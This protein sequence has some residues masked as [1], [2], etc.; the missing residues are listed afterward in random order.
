MC[1]KLSRSFFYYIF[2]YRQALERKQLILGRLVDI[3]TDLFAM[4][5]TLAYAISLHE[6]ENRT[7]SFELADT[8][9]KITSH[10][11]ND[12]YHS[13]HYNEDRSCNALA[14]KILNQEALWL[15]EGIL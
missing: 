12:K 1:K 11:I 5:A 6:K 3:G 7:L 15:E 9:C 14:K 8:F 4:S 2:G 13:L 10:R